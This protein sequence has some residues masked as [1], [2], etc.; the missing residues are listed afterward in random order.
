MTIKF[1]ITPIY[2]YGNDHYYHEIIALAE[3]LQ[4]LGH[5]I[6]SNTDYWFN[7]DKNKYLLKGDLK[8]DYDIAIYDF[9]YVKS[10]EHLLF[11]KGY[12]NIDKNKIN[13]LVDRNDWITP[14]WHNNR[15][16]QIFNL[17]LAGH[18]L[19]DINYPKNVRPWAIGL[20]NRIIDQ[21]N[22]Y[23]DPDVKKESVLGHN[24]RVPHNL[25]RLILNEIKN[26][27]IPYPLELCL[28][29]T[30]QSSVND[31]PGNKTDHHYWQASTRR[32]NPKYYKL[33]NNKL[34]FMTFGGY[35]EF[36]PIAYQPYSL[37]EKMARKWYAI[38]Y[39]TLKYF[40]KDVSPSIFVF[41]YDNFRLWEV[42]FSAS[43]PVNLNFEKWGFAL[44]VNPIDEKHYLGIDKL[45][46]DSFQ[47][48]LNKFSPEQIEQIGQEGRKWVL[49]N[50][51]PSAQA[52]RMLKYLESI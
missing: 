29:D 3:G 36:R 1:F 17:I 6:I 42:L 39:N 10:F 2:P 30:Q 46:H 9:R 40:N 28:T 16:Y 52:L 27:A 7:P 15:H 25:R 51:S 38:Q 44:P 26:K 34:L 35:Y 20:T 13:I 18:L 24:F 41:Q 45:T 47:K 43:C 21:T 12:P 32:H 11:R 22:K 19:K 33:L 23:F 48:K 50:Y 5:H 31:I 37:F 4:E 14:I 49:E 8:A